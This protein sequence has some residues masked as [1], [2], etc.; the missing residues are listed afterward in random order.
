MI[1]LFVKNKLIMSVPYECRKDYCEECGDCM[2]CFT[3]SCIKGEGCW[4]A[5][6]EFKTIEDLEKWVKEREG[7]E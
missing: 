7:V 6:K 5:D 4:V 3:W 1:K 2:V